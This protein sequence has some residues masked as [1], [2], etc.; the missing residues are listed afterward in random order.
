VERK[1][2]HSTAAIIVA[3]GRGVR[4][5]GDLP[6]QWRMVAG[7]KLAAH[8]METFAHHPRID[9]LTLVVHPNDLDSRPWP[10]NPVAEIVCGADTRCG[11]VFAGL[12]SIEGKFEHVLI[13]DAARPCVSARLINDI[14]DA[15]EDGPAAAP[16]LA[17]VDALWR[18]T[19]GFVSRREDRR[20]LFRAQTPQGFNLAQ[21]LTAHRMYQ[22]DAADDVEIAHAAGLPVAIVPGDERN[23]K[24]TS[25]NDFYR[26]ETN[27]GVHMNM[28]LG[29]GFD[30]H[31]FG[32]GSNIIICGVSIP[33]DRSLQ[34][35]S[36]A[37]VGMHAITDAIYGALAMGD[38][39]HHFPPSNPEW[40]DA[41][42]A[43][44]L[45]HSVELAARQNY[46][47]ASID[48]TL[49]CEEPKIGPYAHQMRARIADI[50]KTDSSRISIK[51]TTSERLGF[52]G[53]GEGIAA[54]ATAL[55]V[56]S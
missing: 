44:F 25:P 50:T 23:F 24:V 46:Q 42:S 21:I 52:P 8:S 39:G 2:G 43:I 13:H 51:A 28:R 48:C 56:A 34:G 31:R 55:L 11:S 19:M 1:L 29:N 45:S 37:D 20:H 6:K 53:R 41:K 18:G 4:A 35:H 5:G 10:D 33:F 54:L 16:A 32:S 3:A 14:C 27:L 12:Q 36:D 30:V 40:K 47:I 38:I 7:R 17:V 26:A 49:I 9:H 22:G 15:L